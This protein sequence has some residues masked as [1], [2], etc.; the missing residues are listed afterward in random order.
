MDTSVN[1]TLGNL[2]DLNL[3]DLIAKLINLLLAKISM[4]IELH[5]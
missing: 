4:A 1:I 3:K 2:K 5:N